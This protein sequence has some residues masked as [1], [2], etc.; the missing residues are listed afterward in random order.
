LRTGAPRLT[1]T[2][3]DD[4]SEDITDILPLADEKDNEAIYDI[5]A[6]SVESSK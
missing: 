4:P 6:F 1:P 2:R 5:L 3:E